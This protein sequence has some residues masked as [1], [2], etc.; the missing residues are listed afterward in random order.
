MVE[1]V[2]AF[3]PEPEKDFREYARLTKP[4]G[5]VR[6]NE[7]TWIKTPSPQVEEHARTFMTGARFRNADG[8][9]SLLEQAGSEEI[10]VVGGKFKGG[11]QLLDEMKMNEMGERLKAQDRFLKGLFTNPAYRC[12]TGQILNQPGMMFRFTNHIGHRL[13]TGASRVHKYYPTTSARFH[14]SFHRR[15]QQVMQDG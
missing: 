13:Y 7:A 3:L 5:Y 11:A 1:S 15:L 6:I 4:G 14:F 2:Y 12:Y 10:R 8:W 9:R